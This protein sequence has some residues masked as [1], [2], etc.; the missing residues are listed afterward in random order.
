MN[1]PSTTFSVSNVP[2]ATK[3]LAELSYP[4]AIHDF[5]SRPI[6]HQIQSLGQRI[7]SYESMFQK[8]DRKN[9]AWKDDWVA[10][11]KQRR[12]TLELDVDSVTRRIEACNRY[13]GKLVEGVQSHPVI[14][15]LHFAFTDHRPVRLSPDMFW[16]LICQG[17]AHHI[18]AN[19]EELRADLVKHTG[20]VE[21]RIERHDFVKGSLENPWDE[22]IDEMSKQVADYIGPTQDLFIPRF[23]TTGKTERIAAEIVLLDAMQS[24]FRYVVETSC[25][26][27]EITLEGTPDDWKALAERATEFSRFGLGWW[28]QA[29]EPVLRQIAKGATGNIDINFWKSIYKFSDMSGGGVVTGWITAFFPYLA[30]SEGV[31]N[32]KNNWLASHANCWR[33]DNADRSRDIPRHD[34]G[35]SL[36][37][38]PNGI[39]RAPFLWEYFNSLLNMEFLGGFVGIAQDAE[40]LALRP[41]IGWAIRDVTAAA[42]R[43]QADVEEIVEQPGWAKC[44]R[45]LFGR[46]QS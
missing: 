12:A 40:T 44:I 37:A 35:P 1:N 2:R 10:K 41:E 3:A 13:H 26:I 29:I 32:Q 16:L 39:A 30:N 46:S 14:S 4:E 34:S 31:P 17:V 18:N 9:V 28:T 45:S 5:L 8:L 7:E 27:P 33:T 25:G 23:S 24:Y 15:A 36:D 19:S 20:R 42:I 6:L 11:L 22:A 38:F 43:E 21:I